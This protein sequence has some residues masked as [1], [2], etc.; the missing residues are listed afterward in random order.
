MKRFSLLCIAAFFTT[1]LSAAECSDINSREFLEKST[2]AEDG[3]AW[4][5]VLACVENYP[6]VVNRTD[7]QGYNLLMTAV[8][9][10]IHPFHLDDLISM[11]PEDVYGEALTAIDKRGRSLGHIASAEA[12][13]PGIIFTL[14]RFG[15]SFWEG[16]DEDINSQQAG[17]TPL[18]L[19][20]SREDGFDIVA[21]LLALRNV[22]VPDD[23]DRTPLDIAR[24]KPETLINAM[25]L[26]DGLWPEI[27]RDEFGPEEPAKGAD[28]AN[29]MTSDFFDNADEASVVAC[30][31]EET[32]LQAV[33]DAGNSA[34]HL[35]ALHATDSWIVDHILANSDDPASLMAKRNS[36]GKTA[37][38]LAAEASEEP[39]MVLTLLA[40]GADPEMHFKGQKNWV[41]KDRGITALHLAASRQDDQRERI[42]LYLLAFGADTMAQTP[43]DTATTGGRTALHHALLNPDPVVLSML[44]EAQWAQESLIGNLLRSLSG[45]AVK[46]IEDDFGYTALHIAASRPSDIDTLWSLWTYGFSPDKGDNQGN[47]PLMFAAQNFEDPELFLELLEWSENPCGASSTGVTVESAIRSNAFLNASTADILSGKSLSTLARLKLK[48]PG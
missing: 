32:Q 12:N 5:E 34:L 10:D 25:L 4:E 47:T 21:A 1:E 17:M 7:K 11:I 15:V 18:H 16:I 29:F 36:F 35:A 13:H 22:Q 20:A 48:C 45:K 42:V 41:K 3:T 38:H 31:T 24:G 37:L 28:C 14:S 8:G 46:Q 6:G 23:R 33:D 30:L 43:G 9:S 26:A 39:G 44:L 27:Y 2:S 40:W 19:A